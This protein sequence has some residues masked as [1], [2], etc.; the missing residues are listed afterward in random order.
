MSA[1]EWTLVIAGA[2]LGSYLLR[3]APFLWEQLRRLGQR[4]FRLLTYVS[5]AIAAGI[6]SR[7][8]VYAGGELASAGDIGIKLAAV[9]AALA[10]LAATR[11]LPLALFAGVGLA[12]GLKAL[13]L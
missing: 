9:A 4:Y 6:V 1:L 13:G 12:A 5:L 2:G 10:A 11:S 7:S 8:I 3:V